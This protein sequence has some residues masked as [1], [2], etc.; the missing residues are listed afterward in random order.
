MPY[1]QPC[2]SCV[3]PSS[4]NTNACEITGSFIPISLKVYCKTSSYKE[5]DGCF[6]L[7]TDGADASTIVWSK[8]LE[9]NQ[10]RPIDGVRKSPPTWGMITVCEIIKK[11]EDL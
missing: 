11:L 8:T 1:A 6:I 7:G 2:S 3:A 10:D 5:S 4:E 9:P